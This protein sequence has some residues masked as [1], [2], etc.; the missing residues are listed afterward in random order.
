MERTVSAMSEDYPTL[1]GLLVG[2]AMHPGL[3]SCSVETPLRAVARM[4]ATY[5]VHA[6]LVTGHGDDQLAGGLPWGIASDLNVV[7]AAATAAVDDLKA[8][9]VAGT[10]IVM[11]SSDQELGHAAELMVERAVSHLLVVEPHSGRPF[12]V[13]S[14]LDLA[15]ALAGFPERHP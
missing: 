3:V 10:P 6:V 5:R 13:I 9:D 11:V 8:R 1:Q 4:M 14:T 15:R 7:Q 2:D 12:G